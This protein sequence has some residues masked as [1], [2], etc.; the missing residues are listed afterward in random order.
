M[1]FILRGVA[2]GPI[3]LLRRLNTTHDILALNK[4]ICREV[5]NEALMAVTDRYEVL[6]DLAISKGG[7][8]WETHC[9]TLGLLL[10]HDA[11]DI[12]DSRAK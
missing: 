6:S 12:L 7:G 5:E 10:E 2:L 4:G 8:I 3:T 11:F 1:G 9:Q